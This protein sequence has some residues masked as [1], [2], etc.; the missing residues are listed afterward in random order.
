[1]PGDNVVVVQRPG[2][3]VGDVAQDVVADAVTVPV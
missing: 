1:V 2:E 3:Q